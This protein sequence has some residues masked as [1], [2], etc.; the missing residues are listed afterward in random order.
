MDLSSS[1][2]LPLKE[3]Q[4]DETEGAL[5]LFSVHPDVGT[6]HEAV[7]DIEAEGLVMP[8]FCVG[9]SSRTLDMCQANGAVEVGNRY[10]LAAFCGQK[11]VEKLPADYHVAS[12]DRFRIAT[13]RE[14][15]PWHPES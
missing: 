14:G 10:R 5:V 15:R 4:S 8:G 11:Y 6:L 12:R 1:G 3:I 9:S 13:I 2:N 7:V